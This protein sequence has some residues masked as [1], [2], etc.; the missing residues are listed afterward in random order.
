MD[1]SIHSHNKSVWKLKSTERVFLRWSALPA[2]LC[3]SV[4]S[5]SWIPFIL[6]RY[7]S[8]NVKNSHSSLLFDIFMWIGF[9][10]FFGAL[11]AIFAKTKGLFAQQKQPSDE[12]QQFYNKQAR[13]K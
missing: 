5:F 8:Y 11:R 1:G 13:N 2:S 9:I 10:L 4:S 6:F 3:L 12:T 7:A